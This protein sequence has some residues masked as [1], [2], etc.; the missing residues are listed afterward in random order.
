MGLLVACR[1]SAGFV[2]LKIRRK[3]NSR[4]ILYARLYTR[5]LV[6]L[7]SW[8]S[9]VVVMLVGDGM[10][11]VVVVVVVTRGDREWLSWFT[12]VVVRETST[13]DEFSHIT[14]H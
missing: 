1:R 8:W 3:K 7:M 11:V 5:F 9:C 2:S 12:M 13:C 10:E 6:V 4:R 14:A